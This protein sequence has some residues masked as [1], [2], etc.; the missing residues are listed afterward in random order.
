MRTKL[1]IHSKYALASCLIVLGIVAVV[2][3]SWVIGE[4]EIAGFGAGYIP[5]APLTA[6]L[7]CFLSLTTITQIVGPQGLLI[8]CCVMYF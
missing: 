2:S 3:I 8:G 1:E 5:M 4:P 6:I 7:F